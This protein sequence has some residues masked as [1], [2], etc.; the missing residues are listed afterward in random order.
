MNNKPNILIVDDK[1]ENLIALESVLCDLHVN[2]IRAI[3][4]NEALIKILEHEF[5]LALLDIQMP[6]MDGYETLELIRQNKKTELL[7]VIFVTAIYSDKHS[8]IKGIE[9]G[10]IDFIVKP[11]IPEILIGKVNIF[12]SL[13]KQRKKLEKEI[14]RRKSAEKRLQKSFEILQSTMNGVM[15]AMSLVVETKDPYTAGHQN[16]V[17][18]LSG[19]I[20]AKLGLSNDQID[21]VRMAASIHD[22]GKVH[23]PADILSKP[24]K[25]NNDEFNIIKTHPV[26]GYEILKTIEFPYPIAEIIYQHHEKVDGSGYPNGLSGNDI[27]LESKIICV[28]DVV[29]AMSS[30]R[31]YRPALG[32]EAAKKEITCKKGILYDSEVVDICIDIINSV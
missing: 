16:K 21:C 12:L 26:I 30:H 3:S 32:I 5:A 9:K 22:L 18:E 8:L 25:I 23:V 17:A 10:A 13:D 29:D 24:G 2:L 11:I 20:A 27:R 6:D 31:P 14:K 15:N 28:A 7:P 4:G 1:V 19:A